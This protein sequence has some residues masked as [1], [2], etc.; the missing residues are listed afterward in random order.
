MSLDWFGGGQKQQAVTT[1]SVDYEAI[2]RQERTRMEADS[3]SASKAAEATRT[4]EADKQRL[5]EVARAGE[6]W[7][8]S[9]VRQ[10]GDF[11][12]NPSLLNPALFDT[13]EDLLGSSTPVTGGQSNMRKLMGGNA[14]GGY[15]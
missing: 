8:R 13:E 12:A 7:R 15:R 3:T 6:A 1:S 10:P 14:G 4:A 2:R 11:V 5:A 9:S